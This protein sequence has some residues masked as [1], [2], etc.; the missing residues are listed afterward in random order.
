MS[1]ILKDLNMGKKCEDKVL[2][3]LNDNKEKD[4]DDYLLTDHHHL[5]DYINNKYIIEL[6]SRNNN[7]NK[8]PTTMVGFNKIQ[9]IEENKTDKLYKFLFLFKDGIYC[10][11]YNKD[12]YKVSRGGRKDRGKYEF[13][14]YAYIN[15]KYLKLLSNNITSILN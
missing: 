11:D 10:W 9:F 2:K 14:N 8:Y 4:D 1:K 6:K 5:F 7:Y 13:K 15:I 3:F 12:E